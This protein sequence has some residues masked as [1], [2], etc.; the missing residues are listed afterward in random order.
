ML[1]V[2]SIHEHKRLSTTTP[3]ADSGVNDQ[4]VKLSPLIN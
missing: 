1:S 4:L 3:L 2:L